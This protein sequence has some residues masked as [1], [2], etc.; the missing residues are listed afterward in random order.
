MPIVFNQD[1]KT[2]QT[3]LRELLEAAVGVAWN[4]APERKEEFERLY[5]KL[6]WRFQT[7]VTEGTYG[8][9][10][11]TVDEPPRNVI[12]LPLAALERTWAYVYAYLLLFDVTRA[13]PG[14]EITSEY[15]P[16]V[17]DAFELLNWANAGERAK[18]RLDWPDALPRPDSKSVD[19]ARLE[20]TNEFFLGALAFIVLHEVAHIELGHTTVKKAPD[21]MKMNNER[22][23]DYWAAKWLFDRMTEYSTEEKFRINRGVWVVL[24]LAILNLVEFNN[25][26]GMPTSHPPTIERL[27]TFLNNFCPESLEHIAPL[28]DFPTFLAL[29]IIECQAMNLNVATR[30]KTYDSLTERLI[31]LLREFERKY[32]R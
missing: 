17:R 11:D 26:E 22:A 12:D 19:A 21:N 1:P 28:T 25:R 31:D 4:A 16:E 5:E 10:A 23:A 8:F 14:V 29:T 18:K 2:V 6:A 32:N 30:L 9:S 3:P 27:L 20:K 7:D 15:S 24:A 13:N